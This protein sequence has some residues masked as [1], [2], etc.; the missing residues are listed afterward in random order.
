M[1]DTYGEE[2]GVRN[3][4]QYAHLTPAQQAEFLWFDRIRGGSAPHNMA[5]NA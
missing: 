2:Q 3:R 1:A 4:A 5:P